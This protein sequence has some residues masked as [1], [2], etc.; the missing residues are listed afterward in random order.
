MKKTYLKDLII[1]G[2]LLICGSSF[3]QVPEGGTLLN[4]STGSTYQKIGK[5]TVSEVA[6]VDQPFTKA[7]NLVTGSDVLNTWDAQVQFPS[8]AGIVTDDV[9]LVSFYARTVSSIQETG[10]GFAMV[11]IENSSTYAKEIYM[12]VSIGKEWKQYYA[13]VKSLST[14]T[15]SRA[16]YALFAGFPSQT[17]EIADVRFL[18][19]FKTLTLNDLPVT[20]ITYSGRDAD[21][22]WRAPA[23]ERIE[24]IRKGVVDVIIYDELG[25]VVPDATVSIEM[26]QHQF[27]FGSAIP[28]G[29]FIS[30][31]VFREKVYENFNE[32]V[33]EN[34]LKWPQF[35]P[36]STLNIRK[37]LDSLDK[38]NIPVRGHNVIWP[39]WRW[40]PASL[41]SLTT[42]PVA[43]RNE[44]DK[45][46]DQIT[47]FASGRLNDWDVINEPYSEKDI[48]GILGNEVMADWLKRT[49]QNDRAVK[50][51]INDYGILSAGGLDTKKQDSYYNLIKYLDERG[52][53]V[54]GIGM[55]GHFSS[56]LTPITRV[57]TIL[58]RFG[59]LGK[60]IKITEHDIEITQPAVQADYTRDF[61]TIVFSHASVKSLLVWGFYA[62][63]HWKPDAAFYDLD[64]NIRPHG[65]VWKDMI[66]N[67]WWTKKTDSITDANGKTS[68][69]GF[70]GTYKYT[71]IAGDLERSG[72]FSI[73]NSNRSGKSN[74]LA[75]SF[76][77]SIPD[78][79]GITPSKPAVLCEGEDIKLSAPLINDAVYQWF[80]GGDQLA[81]QTAEI[82]VKEAGKYY[83][84]ATKGNLE[85]ISDTLVVVVNPIP[86]AIITAVGDLSFCPGGKVT[87][88]ANVSNDL[89]YNWM[90]GSTKI[91]GSVTS[92]EVSES[93]SYI[94]QT[95]SK[96]CIAVS[97]PVVV[98]VFSASSPECT[99]GLDDMKSSVHVYPNPS[100]G[101]FVI[102][103][104]ADEFSNAHIELFDML[105]SRV[106]FNVLEQNRFQ[107]II[108]LDTPGV[109]SLRFQNNDR[110][111]TYKIIGN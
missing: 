28:A 15:T 27:G 62:G 35:N 70:L 107:T 85:L 99:I 98:E 100:N 49:R 68:F 31:A 72:T 63:S 40:C 69:V 20:E 106:S 101:Y 83:V 95:N 110:V 58:D 41:E 91:Q 55:Q 34:D 19:Y 57:Y 33:F 59:E 2:F 71:V 44:I 105:G 89:T 76:D 16:R 48:M 77:T 43:L 73:M 13:P 17:I 102:E 32:V 74:S 78:N 64:W 108:R 36:S 104:P 82:I 56:D 88:S 61:M 109:Y 86:D 79:F 26:T 93:G 7:L 3:S 81:D 12:K 51:Y 87:L 23:A 54:N 90:K 52:A 84:K 103:T 94:L 60:D 37:S 25:Q 97:E 53:G 38:H 22:A 39:A 14:W 4:V 24:Q 18:N 45:H 42:N 5:I 46:I 67:Q 92:I 8:A 66:Y 21:A 9:I 96:G 111:Q 50:L 65:E 29:V 30:N 10:E 11:V 47:Q 6:V 1:I 80:N 75:L